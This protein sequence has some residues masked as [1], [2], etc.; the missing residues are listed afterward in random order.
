MIGQ[1]AIGDPRILTPHSPTLEERFATLIRHLRL[2]LA[3]EQLFLEA[4]TH[5]DTTISM[6]RYEDLCTRANTIEHR[7]PTSTYT[8]RSPVEF[9]KYL[10][11][12]INGLP[13]N[14]YLKKDLST[15]TDFYSVLAGI[16]HYQNTVLT[17]Y[18][19]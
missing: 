16:Q 19:K 2:M 4:L 1:S 10:F 5:M 3:A 17:V 18:K 6:P 13:E 15:R 11:R 14:K 8:Y 7:L 12:Y 9:R